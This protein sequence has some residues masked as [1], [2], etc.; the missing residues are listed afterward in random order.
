[1]NQVQWDTSYVTGL[2]KVVESIELTSNDSLFAT[3]ISYYSNGNIGYLASK[4]NS[5]L[6]GGYFYFNSDGTLRMYSLYDRGD[7]IIY[8]M[9]SFDFIETWHV[10]DGK[11]HGL[12][13]KTDYEGNIIEEGYFED[14]IYY[15]K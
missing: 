12:Y 3:Y 10:K 1:M 8:R 15:P 5:K 9:H 2:R 13:E 6:H 11:R 7:L 4:S 14:G